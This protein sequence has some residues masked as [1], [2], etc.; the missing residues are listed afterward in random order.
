MLL[1][2]IIF[3]YNMQT[4]GQLAPVISKYYKLFLACIPNS[5]LDTLKLLRPDTEQ[6]IAKYLKFEFHNLFR[7]ILIAEGSPAN[8]VLFEE[9][10]QSEKLAVD[11]NIKTD[12]ESKDEAK[13]KKQIFYS[14]NTR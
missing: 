9:A 8:K 13:G 14:T 7:P 6:Q 5:E 4:N 1:L 11:I 12:K 3:K 10:N 2:K